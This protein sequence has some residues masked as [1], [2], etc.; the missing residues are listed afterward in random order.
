MSGSEYKSTEKLA[1]ALSESDEKTKELSSSY[2]WGKTIVIIIAYTIYVSFLI[3]IKHLFKLQYCL[4][5]NERPGAHNFKFSVPRRSFDTR[6][7]FETHF[8]RAQ[9][10]IMSSFDLALLQDQALIWEQVLKWGNMIFIEMNVNISC[11][12]CVILVHTHTNP[13][14]GLLESPDWL[15]I[16]HLVWP[17]ELQCL[18]DII[19]DTECSYWALTEMLL[20]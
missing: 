10:I 19:H 16:G 7:S 11:W 17:C 9:T 3:I 12:K 8:F 13:R 5:P 2:R 18:G 14:I 20:R 1:D 6:R 4:S 15:W